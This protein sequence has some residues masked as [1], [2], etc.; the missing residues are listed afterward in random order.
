VASVQFFDEK[1]AQPL[2]QS[3][4]KGER[5]LVVRSDM[6]AKSGSRSADKSQNKN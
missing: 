4:R 1:Q 6:A 5:C 3:I 2:R